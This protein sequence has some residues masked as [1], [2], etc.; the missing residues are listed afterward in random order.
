MTGGEIHDVAAEDV[1]KELMTLSKN[2]ATSVVAPT[3]NVAR[4]LVM[5]ASVAESAL[6]C[7]GS[8]L[9]AQPVAENESIS[10]CGE[11]EVREEKG[12]R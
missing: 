12:D 4:A 11:G 7:G 10:A 6:S 5:I 3:A 2:L 8:V 1:P 9:G